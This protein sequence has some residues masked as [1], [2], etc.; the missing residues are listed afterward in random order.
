MSILYKYIL[1]TVKDNQS[2]L[3]YSRFTQSEY[4]FNYLYRCQVHFL[5]VFCLFHMQSGVFFVHTFLF[6]NF[7]FVQHIIIIIFYHYLLSIFAVLL[8]MPRALYENVT[9]VLFFLSW[10]DVTFTFLNKTPWSCSCRGQLVKR[11]KATLDS[12]H[13]WT[14]LNAF[15]CFHCVPFIWQFLPVSPSQSSSPSRVSL[16]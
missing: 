16:W 1:L 7:Y 12:S 4:F 14:S 5:S 13:P 6:C 2:H 15:C 8:V 10:R 3:A 9:F 11:N